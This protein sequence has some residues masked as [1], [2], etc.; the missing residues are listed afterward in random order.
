MKAPTAPK[1][2]APLVLPGT[3]TVT[4]KVGDKE[5]SQPLKVLRDPNSEGTDA[6]IVA[7]K[8][9]L[10]EIKKDLSNAADIINQ[11]EWLRRQ[12][13]DLKSIAEDQK[14]N[15]VTKAVEGLEKKLIEVEGDLI[16]LKVTPQGQGVIRWPAQVVEK[17][18]Y[19]G[20]AIETADFAPAD[21]HKEVQQVLEKRLQDS[22]TKFNQLLEKDLP[23]FQDLLKKNNFNGPI[24]MKGNKVLN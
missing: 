14:N 24:I 1:G 11:M 2:F 15:E 21:Q 16:Q 12:A 22:Q 20:G 9:A 17:L 8:N 13:A 10:N 4:L 19:L 5:Y 23:A 18:E 6:D 3:Y 7:Q